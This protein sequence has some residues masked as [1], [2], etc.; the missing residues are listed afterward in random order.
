M[1][2]LDVYIPHIYSLRPIKKILGPNVIYSS[3]MNLDICISRF[4]VLGCVTS[5]T[6]LVFYGTKGV[7]SLRWHKLER[8]TI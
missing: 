3:T 6:R 1:A 2:I 8:L 5:G 7:D 4:V